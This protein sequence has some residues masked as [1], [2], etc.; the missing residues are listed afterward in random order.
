MSFAVIGAPEDRRQ[1]AIDMHSMALAHLPGGTM[2]EDQ[3]L[4]YRLLCSAVML[5]PSFALGWYWLGNANVDMNLRASAAAA[6]QRG[7]NC[8][9][10]LA[11]GDLAPELE[12]K[13]LVNLGHCLYHLGELFRAEMITR[14]AL[15]IQPDDAMALV[16]LSLIRSHRGDH[17]GAIA[18]AKRAFALDPRPIIETGLAFAQLFAGDYAEGMRHFEARIAYRIPQMSP[19]SFPFKAWSGEDA[20]DRTLY[21][22]AEQGA[23]DCLSFLRFVPPAI[24]RVGRVILHVHPELAR[25]AGMMLK[26]WIDRQKC[27]VVAMGAP[28]PAADFWCPIGSLPVMLDLDDDQIRHAEGLT[29]PWWGVPAQW[30]EATAKHHIAVAWAGSPINDV[31]RWRTFP[32]ELLL[33]LSGVPGVQLY[34]VQVGPRSQDLYSTGSAAVIRDLF[35]MIRDACDTIAIMREM[36]LVICVESFPRHLA[37]A[38]GKPCWVPLSYMGGDWR[39]GR[40]GDV[41]LWDQHTRLIRQANTLHWEPVFEQIRAELKQWTEDRT[42]D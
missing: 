11:A 31:D 33:P 26:P 36:D 38:L 19:A 28:F 15:R 18:D 3:P 27:E 42:T 40:E 14:K 4:A 17:K 25:L 23:G 7:L 1:K 2:T 20:P 5:D 41:P 9:K 16:N 22:V 10:G 13:L 37:G 21:I 35:P 8:P 6:F 29:I 24:D 39:C 34:S 32:V 12:I 30:K